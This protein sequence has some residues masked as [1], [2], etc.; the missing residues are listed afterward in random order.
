[1]PSQLERTL[2]LRFAALVG[3]LI[4]LWIR[5]DVI[6]VGLRHWSN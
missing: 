5:W 6:E 4:G 1:M 2:T 3:L